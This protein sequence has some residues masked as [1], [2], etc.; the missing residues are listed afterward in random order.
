MA[1]KQIPD[2]VVA[3][4][5]VY[6]RALATMEANGHQYTSS[7]EMALVLGISAAQ[8]RKD[9]SHF[10]EFGKQGTGYS[11]KSLQERLRRIL[12][13]EREWG[14]VIIGAGNIGSA[15][16]SYSGFEYR[17]FRVQAVFDNDPN[18]IGTQIGLF[19]IKDAQGLAEF[20]QAN[21]VHLAMIAVPARFAQVVADQAVAAGITAILNYAPTNLTVPAKV[22]VENIDPVLHLQ[23][24]TYYL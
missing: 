17:G 10:G 8:I 19:V 15:V 13:L 7:Q 20:V 21:D 3:R 6:L 11:V 23:H 18:K 4:L 14:L 9:L 1:A 5:P 2:I 22:H 12:K 24:M 16:A